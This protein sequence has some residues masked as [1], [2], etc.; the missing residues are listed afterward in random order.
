MKI[1][2]IIPCFNEQ[3]T[4]Q[5]LL[6][7]I[8]E[9][10]YPLS[11]L[12]VI[13]ADG[14]SMDATRQKIQEFSAAVP[15]LTIKIVDNQDRTIP[16]AL[17]RA[18]D[19]AAGEILVRMDAHS[20]PHPDYLKISVRDLVAGKGDNVGGV[21]DIKPA[22]Q[23]WI[24]RS[25]A[26]AAGHPLGV[27]DAKYRTGAGAGEVDTVA[28]GTFRATLIDEVGGFDESLLTNED[29]E[30]N[31]RVRK[32]GKVI[33]LNPEIK[34]TYISRPSL[35]SLAA[36]YWRYGYWKLRMLLRYP[37]TFRWRQLS[38]FFVLS[39]LGLGLLS[40]W[41]PLARWLLLG[42]AV[43]YGGALLAAGLNS[44]VSQKDPGLALGL[45]LAI[46][47]MHF[48]WGSGFIISL[49]RYSFDK[50]VRKPKKDH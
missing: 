44:A 13:I 24:G 45:P 3:D 31:V 2:L 30:F 28:F 21:I 1:S 35:S 7:A 32:A 29:Y 43:L 22:N 15:E 38:G 26:Q 50:I 23:S 11:D 40:I 20:L 19:A 8:C 4:I 17:N 48:S 6:A 12:E 37:E 47:T 25:I 33:W 49:A 5:D 14:M 46:A 16:A 34:A 36:Q 18:I 41:F 42:E 27:G 10:D 9:Q 39:W